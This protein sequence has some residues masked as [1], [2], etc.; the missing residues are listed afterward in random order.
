MKY[1]DTT[2]IGGE[3][4]RL[5]TT[6]TRGSGAGQTMGESKSFSFGDRSVA[7]AYDD[8]LVPVLFGPWAAKLVEQHQPWRGRRVLDLATGTGVVARLLAEQVG[9]DGK[10]LAAD[11]N[12]EMLAI[13][14]QRCDSLNPGI[15]FIQCPARLLDVANDS[16]DFVVC[17]QGFQFFPERG[18]AVGEIF[19]VLSEGGK[20]VAS[21][22]RPVNEC[23]FFG[24]V[25]D[26]LHA[27]GE[28]GIADTMRV[29][30]DFLKGAELKNHFEAAGFSNV[31]LEQQQQDMVMS[32]G[33][34]HPAQVAYATPIGPNLRELSRER[35]EQFQAQ[36]AGVVKGLSDDGATLGRM[37]SNVVT[38]EKPNG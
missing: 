17:Q 5:A 4:P 32:A 24:A 18:A 19:R 7:Y 6:G 23:Q 1:T 30:F 3:Q 16:I 25:C 21:T 26:A 31:R 29:P 9:E 22:W 10:V 11:A 2:D 35:Q 8:V 36:L 34:D 14:K 13:A 37:V 20:V 12:G 28:P 27:I 38:A 33:V 15:E